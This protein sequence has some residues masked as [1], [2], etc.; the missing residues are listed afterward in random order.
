[1]ATYKKRGLK[2]RDRKD[3]QSLESQ[4][5]TAEVFKTLDQTASKSEQW[6]E[7]NKTFLFNGLVVVIVAILGYMG[8]YK[9]IIEPTETEASNELAFPRAY[10]DQSS[11]APPSEVDSLL[12]LGLDGADGKY[13]FLDIAEMYSGTKAGNIAN[14]YA[15]VSY[16][17]LKDYENAIDFLSQFDSDDDILGPTALGAIGDAFADIDQEQEALEYYEKAAYKKEND[18]TTPLFLYKAGK[19][20]MQLD[21]F[22]KAEQFFQ[23]IKDDYSKTDIGKD[24]DKYLSSAV[25]A[26]Q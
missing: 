9:Y 3:Q 1:M 22:A 4:S 26:Q 23:E 13:G 17:K 12:Q 8:Y 10:F 24:I 2:P 5:A 14:Y 6:I 15:G 7:K 20:A 19:T 11:V 18:F 21:Q 25:Y 16:L